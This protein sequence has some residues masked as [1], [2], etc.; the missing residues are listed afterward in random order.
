MELVVLDQ[1]KDVLL[2][3]PSVQSMDI[4]NAAVMYLVDQSVDLALETWN[5][6]MMWLGDIKTITLIRNNLLETQIRAMVWLAMITLQEVQE[7]K[8]K[9]VVQVKELVVLVVMM[10]VQRMLPSVQN[11]DIVNAVHTNQEDLL[12]D[13]E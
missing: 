9:C 10:G 7:D 11:M 12:V 6:I 2:K 8:L 13:Q 4:V 5:K 1:V 3:L